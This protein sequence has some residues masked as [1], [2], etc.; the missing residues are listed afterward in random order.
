MRVWAAHAVFAAVLVGSL[1]SRERSAE[2]PLIDAGL[3]SVVLSVARSQGLGFREY[4]TSDT[5]GERT[6]AFNVP[7]CSQP[8]FGDLRMATFEDEA[9]TESAP[10]QDY[11][12]AYVYFDRKWNSPDRWAVSIQTMKYSLLAMFGRTDY[13]T[14]SLVLEVEAPRDC[15]AAE[16][17]DWRPAW[18]RTYLAINSKALARGAASRH[19]QVERRE[20]LGSLRGVAGFLPPEFRTEAATAR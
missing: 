8:M 18:S 2:A 11:Q 1:A 14:S 10:G 7:G 17:I 19:R 9:T 20:T 12:Q 16:S 3:E 13:A 5:G 4:R 6:M 15:P